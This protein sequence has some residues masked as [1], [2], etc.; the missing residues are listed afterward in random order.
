MYGMDIIEKVCR[1]MREL[2]LFAGAGGGILGGKMLG[3][4]TVCA[5]EIEPW[6]QS[7]LCARQNEGTL[8]AFPIWDDVCTFDGRA[9][10]GYVDVISGGF[11]C[12]DI[13]A[14][15]T[16]GAGI[17]GVRSGLWAQM[18][19]IIQE[20][21][22]RFVFVENSPMLIHR[23]MGRVL[24]DLASMGYDAEYGVMGADEVGANH[25]RKR[26]WILAGRVDD[27]DS[28]RCEREGCQQ[29]Q[30]REEGQ[31]VTGNAGVILSNTPNTRCNGSGMCEQ[32][33]TAR[34]TFTEPSEVVSNASSE[35]MEGHS[36]YI[37]NGEARTSPASPVQALPRERHESWGQ[38]H[39]DSGRA[40][41][42]SWTDWCRC[43]VTNPERTAGGGGK[44]LAE[45]QEAQGLRIYNARGN[46]CY[47][48][49]DWWQAEPAVGRVANGMADRV[50]RLKATGNG[51]V[52]AVAAV[53]FVI[54]L[55]RLLEK[56][57]S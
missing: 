12:Q 6:C 9:W 4:R 39:T 56:K 46:E 14:A 8:E 31:S 45:T 15:N 38:V 48:F 17:S 11:P 13:S 37:R 26:M 43:F 3:W 22:P 42:Q 51:Q 28:A 49:N 30:R 7:V 18:F 36:E 35:V 23:G 53:M 57:K 2:A 54:L 29:D 41:A 55:R 5:V 16:K 21:R 52:P 20:V 24:G 10:E 44:Q 27:T 50:D 32:N 1:G 40:D 33:G 47:G 34:D 19:R 25:E